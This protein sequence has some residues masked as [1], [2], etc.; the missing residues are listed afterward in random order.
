M[1]EH[2]SPGVYVEETRLASQPIAATPTASAAFVGAASKGPLDSPARVTSFAEYAER[3]GS[4][5]PESPLS[6]AVGHFFENGG[7]EGVVVR[8]A[9][10]SLRGG[11]RVTPSSVIG[12]AGKKTGLRALT[13]RPL[14]AL[15]LTPDACTMSW[16]EHD[17]LARGVLAF[18]AAHRLFH[19][20]DPPRPRSVRA[21]VR[22]V[23]EW[24]ARSDTPRHPNAA[25]YFPRLRSTG[26]SGGSAG[27]LAPASGAVAGVY[28]R[29]DLRRGVWQAPAGP[30]T[31]IHGIGGVEVDPSD[32]DMQRLLAAGVNALRSFPGIGVVVWG[33][34]TFASAASDA[35]WKYVPVRR[36]ALF[37]ERS[38]HEGL[39]WTVFEPN[40]AALWAQVRLCVSSFLNHLFLR[41][42]L[43]GAS[44]REAYFVRCG[45]GTMTENDIRE[46]RV[47]VLVGFAPLKPAEFTVL[48]LVLG[49]G[50]AT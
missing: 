12:D 10:R 14:P 28:A 32:R 3:F 24:A 30:S 13:E 21:P 17:A 29:A 15:L 7:Q 8:V 39:R 23:C 1:H 6:L 36:F 31:R 4:D 25:V 18:C 2:L 49:A 20:A 38:L 27:V 43:A 5:S 11:M 45:Q 22:S 44:A 34:R 41:G 48:R 35:E 37:L 16:R 33:A 46:G 9:A 40:G 47:V 42:A 19:V 26:S 50:D